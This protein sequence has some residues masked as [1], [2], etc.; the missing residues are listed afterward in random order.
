M[1]GQQAIQLAAGIAALAL[2]CSPIIAL[3]IKDRLS[4]RHEEHRAAIRLI[5]RYA[6]TSRTR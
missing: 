5:L 3:R 4:R 6:T 2:V 1:S